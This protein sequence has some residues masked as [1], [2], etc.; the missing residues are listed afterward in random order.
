[1]THESSG[2]QDAAQ[3][4][5]PQAPRQLGRRLPAGS[6]GGSVKVPPQLPGLARTVPAHTPSPCLVTSPHSR[7]LL[8]QNSFL[9]K[10]FLDWL[11]LRD[12][13]M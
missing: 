2:G 1:M 12:D 10:T 6:R 3:R 7:L 4:L 9:R 5:G 13:D 8:V 11:S